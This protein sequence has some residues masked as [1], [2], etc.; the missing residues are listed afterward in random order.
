[1]AAKVN[2]VHT[3]VVSKLNDEDAKY[4]FDL[5]IDLDGNE[6]EVLK[7]YESVYR[8]FIRKKVLPPLTKAITEK[9]ICNG[10]Q[11]TILD[12][13]TAHALQGDTYIEEIQANMQYTVLQAALFLTITVGYYIEPPEFES[14]SMLRAFVA[15]S[16]LS[17]VLQIIVVVMCT[18][19]SAFLNRASTSAD[20]MVARV[21]VKTHL[22]LTFLMNYVADFG[23]LLIMLI[24]GFSRSTIDGAVQMYAGAVVLAVG[25]IFVTLNKK[26]ARYVM[27]RDRELHVMLCML[28]L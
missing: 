20:T 2:P 16:G 26:G 10:I 13:S 3:V 17:G 18:I 15:L 24:A 27:M 4:N 19:L 1:M 8:S 11:G 6:E 21:E 23:I 25:V 7:R 12:F 28:H 5:P 9:N 14:D 22:I